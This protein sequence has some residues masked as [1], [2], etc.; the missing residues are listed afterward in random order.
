M[1]D[2]LYSSA[3]PEWPTP[4]AFFDMLDAEFIFTLDPCATP[5]NAKCARFYTV[6]DDGL[7]QTWDGVVWMNPPYGATIGR[8][9]KKAFHEARRGAVVVA[10]VPARTD[11]RW[12]HDYVMKAAEIRLVRGRLKFGDATTGAPFPSAV[13]VFRPGKHT[14]RLTAIKRLPGLDYEQTELLEAA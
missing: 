5:E 7:K 10:L 9:I 4:R 13:V 14:P 6:D 3:T 8:W 11:T 1:N 12:W 2:A